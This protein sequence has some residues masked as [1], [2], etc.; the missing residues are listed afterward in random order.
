MKKFVLCCFLFLSACGE[1]SFQTTTTEQSITSTDN[2]S[3][4]LIHEIN[5]G[6]G[7]SSAE[8]NS[9]S[10]E[11]SIGAVVSSNESTDSDILVSLGLFDILKFEF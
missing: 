11:T 1:K 6:G 9:F 5:S 8:D 2:E 4:L 3:L 7:I 10:A